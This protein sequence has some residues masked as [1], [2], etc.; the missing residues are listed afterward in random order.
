VIILAGSRPMLLAEA[1]RALRPGGRFD[2]S[3]MIAA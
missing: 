3:E 1:A 2:V